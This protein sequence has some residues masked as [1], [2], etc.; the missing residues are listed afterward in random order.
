MKEVTTFNK[1]DAKIKAGI[2]LGLLALAS[3]AHAATIEVPDF[4]EIITFIGGLA[5]AISA[6]GLAILALYALAKSFKL[7]RGAF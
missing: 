2:V 6:I 1:T 5:A 3:N 4:S 7:V